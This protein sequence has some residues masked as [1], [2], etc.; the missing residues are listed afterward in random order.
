MQ[1]LIWHGQ[2][3]FF[4][5]PQGGLGIYEMARASFDDE[6]RQSL[7]PHGF[8][9]ERAVMAGIGKMQ[10]QLHPVPNCGVNADGLTV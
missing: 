9:A 1:A 7:M 5:G 6:G 8:L 3:I 10:D 4:I 2:V